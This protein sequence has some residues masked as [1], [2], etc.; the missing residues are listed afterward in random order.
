MSYQF[1][2]WETLVAV[3]VSWH[4]TCTTEFR[5]GYLSPCSIDFVFLFSVS[6]KAVKL[7]RVQWWVNSADYRFNAFPFLQLHLFHRAL[8]SAIWLPLVCPVSVSLSR[9]SLRSLSS[10]SLSVRLSI[11]PCAQVFWVGVVPVQ[12]ITK[13]IRWMW[14]HEDQTVWNHYESSRKA[15]PKHLHAP[16]WWEKYPLERYKLGHW[17][18]HKLKVPLKCI[19]W[20]F[21]WFLWCC[22]PFKYSF[23]RISLVLFLLISCLK[24]I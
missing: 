10:H 15:K 8:P 9:C 18:N 24:L 11:R 19:F 6:L 23:F 12:S 22:W 2:F 16:W 1:A 4:V 20:H 5:S 13:I 14:T 7:I 17:P 3:L 21:R